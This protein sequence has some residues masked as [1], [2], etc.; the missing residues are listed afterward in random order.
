[1]SR[2]KVLI[3]EDEPKIVELLRLYLEKEGY[4]VVIATDGAKGLE[5]FQREKPS[6]I[7][8]DLMLPV[9]DGL[10]V[11][12]SIRKVSQ[13]PLIILTA[14]GEE[15]DRIL[16]LELG[17]DDYITKPF[18]PREV[19]AR[20]N[21]VLR[22]ATKKEQVSEIINLEELQIDLSQY[23]VR[24]KNKEVKLT[25]TEFKLLSL[26]AQQPGRVFTRLQLLDMAI[27]EIYE[28]YERTIDVHIKNLRQ[29]LKLQE[30]DSSLDIMTIRGVGYKLVTGNV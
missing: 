29:K 7:I 14:R 1:M 17:A 5:L 8:L 28:G 11:C 23:E 24:Y 9:M 26:M 22:R 12:R 19:I 25:P 15:I 18:S 4:Q 6:L 2:G 10:E 16:G 13:L 21:A 20:V 27:G 30:N 3:I